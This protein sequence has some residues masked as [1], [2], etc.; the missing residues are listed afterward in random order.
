MVVFPVE[1][2]S[3]WTDSKGRVLPDAFLVPRGTTARQL[4][5]RVHTD[6]GEGFLKAVDARRKRTLGADHPLEPGDVIR[7]V[8]HR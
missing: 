1:D 3:R 7:V 2:E 8:S 4:A 5:Y 6:L